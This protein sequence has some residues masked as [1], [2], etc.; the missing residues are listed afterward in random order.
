MLGSLCLKVKIQEQFPFFETVLLIGQAVVPLIILWQKFVV[1]T[2]FREKEINS[3][4]T[5]E[6]DLDQNWT[7]FFG[8]GPMEDLK[9]M[10]DDVKDEIGEAFEDVEGVFKDLGNAAKDIGDKIRDEIVK[11]ADIALPEGMAERSVN[12]LLWKMLMF[13]EESA[14][15]VATAYT[16]EL[17]RNLKLDEDVWKSHKTA[18]GVAIEKLKE[19]G[20]E[21]S[22]SVKEGA[23]LS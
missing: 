6:E 18:V 11:I 7:Q 15:Q 2:D 12:S 23:S 16:E 14:T 4:K 20:S 22:S 5:D 13:F 21:G 17:D 10:L 3:A 1:W 8:C 9:N 19:K